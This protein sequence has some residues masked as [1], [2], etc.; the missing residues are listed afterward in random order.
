MALDITRVS[1]TYEVRILNN[2]DVQRVY[3]L[4][5]K[6]EL[7]YQ[8]CPPFVTTESI[9]ADM[10]ALPPGITQD[11]KHYLGFFDSD[12]LIAVMDLILG[13]PDE[14][15]AYI[16]FFMTDVSVQNKG[17]GSRIIRELCRFACSNNFT[18]IQLGWVQGNPQPE[19]FWHKNG[20]HKTDRIYDM[21]DF[22]VVK[23]RKDLKHI[24]Q[25]TPSP[26]EMIKAGTK[27]IELRLYDEK[28][29]KIHVG[30]IIEFVN[31]QGN[32]ELLDVQVNGLHIYDSFTDLY[33]NLPLVASG[34][35]KDDLST[36]SPDDMN[37]YYSAEEQKKYGVIGVEIVVV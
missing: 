15:T 20:F 25:L 30:D 4:C 11:K 16:G 18:N 3:N 23:A 37:E 33:N 10:I 1:E 31:T 32:H 14:D 21:K 27:T 29:R 5:C 36:A 7:Y 26:F 9:K 12:E 28:R 19:H 2:H 17:V 22:S 6:N 8:Y 35:T 24:M 13:Y 34:Y